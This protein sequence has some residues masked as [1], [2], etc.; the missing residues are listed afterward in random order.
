[1]FTSIHST[2]NH[3]ARQHIKNHAPSFKFVDFPK[4]NVNLVIS[5]MDPRAN[6]NEF[7]GISESNPSIGVMRNAGG[8]VTEDVLR[9]VRVISAIIANGR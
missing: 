2:T 5:C 6:P 9:N 8:R 4:R 3:I 1:M 7:W